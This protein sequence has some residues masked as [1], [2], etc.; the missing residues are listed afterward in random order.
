VSNTQYV[1]FDL[2]L[3]TLYL[4]VLLMTLYGA[5]NTKIKF[6]RFKL[7]SNTT[8]KSANTELQKDLIL[9]EI[10]H[11]IKNNL[12]IIISLMNIELE[13]GQSINIEEFV[14]KSQTNIVS[15]ALIHKILSETN[16]SDRIDFKTY[17]S[18][19]TN[20]IKAII[21]ISG[22]TL[23][24]KIETNNIELETKAAINLGLIVN[25]LIMNSHKY[26]FDNQDEKIITISIY[27]NNGQYEFHY[28]DNGKGYIVEKK[29]NT[30]GMNII[31][32]LIKQ[33]RGIRISNQDISTH[34]N[35]NFPNHIN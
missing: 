19:L 13:E 14:K 27:E 7:N 32:M 1:L 24:F 17:L 15:I 8:S 20:N 26:A 28:C 21:T 5:I 16:D 18:E 25:E 23:L 9:Q 30:I 29:P 12:Q 10:H 4:I 6:T 22:E 35:F 3:F 2:I 33:L 34:Y 31:D 11:R